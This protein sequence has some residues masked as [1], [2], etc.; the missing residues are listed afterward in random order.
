[1]SNMRGLDA[2]ASFPY[3][4]HSLFLNRRQADLAQVGLDIQAQAFSRRHLLL[5]V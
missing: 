5:Y 4:Q 2:A 3:L 1:M